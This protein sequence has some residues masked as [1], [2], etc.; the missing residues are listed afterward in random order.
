MEMK[1]EEYYCDLCDERLEERNRVELDV[2]ATQYSVSGKAQWKEHKIDMCL[3]CFRE[4]II[5]R[6]REE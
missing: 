6:W 5:R 1:I 2:K 3:D 4:L